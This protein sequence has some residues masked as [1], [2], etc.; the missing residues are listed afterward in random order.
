[1]RITTVS[2]FI[3]WKLQEKIGLNKVMQKKAHTHTLTRTL[4]MCQH[5]IS[6]G[7]SFSSL[8][9]DCDFCW[10][11]C[12]WHSLLPRYAFSLSLCLPLCI[13]FAILQCLL[14]IYTGQTY[15]HTH[16]LTHTHTHYGV[17]VL[18]RVCDELP[19]LLLPLL[20]LYVLPKM[21][22]NADNLFR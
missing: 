18:F 11:D 17:R 20:L 19:L 13:C 4:I 22:C 8:D 21:C 6:A 16:S 14:G 1:M 5:V 10:L 9:C 3:W 15:T 2:S 12:L 7:T